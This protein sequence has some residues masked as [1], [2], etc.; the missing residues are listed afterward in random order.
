MIEDKS[1]TEYRHIGLLM[2]YFPATCDNEPFV[3]EWCLRTKDYIDIYYI[4]I[5]VI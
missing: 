2:V 5:I 3:F 4:D 1:A